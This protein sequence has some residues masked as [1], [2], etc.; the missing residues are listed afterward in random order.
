MEKGRATA[1]ADLRA[2]EAGTSVRLRVSGLDLAPGNGYELWCISKRGDWISGGTFR[3]SRGGRADVELTSA[4][5]P[6]DYERVL[7]TQA[8]EREPLMAGHVE[9]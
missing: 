7:I 2:V 5:R 3:V 6:G 4:A 1:T 8:G 9:Y